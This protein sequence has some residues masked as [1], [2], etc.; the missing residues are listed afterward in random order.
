[1]L[2]QNQE[3]Q[4]L[5][6]VGISEGC[7]RH[8]QYINMEGKVSKMWAPLHGVGKLVTEDRP[9]VE[10]YSLLPLLQVLTG[11]VCALRF[12]HSLGSEVLSPGC[13][14]EGLLILHL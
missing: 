4:S 12:G 6:G 9:V 1:M 7:E 14:R 2:K 13:L 5:A 8:F 3:S 11:E 10:V